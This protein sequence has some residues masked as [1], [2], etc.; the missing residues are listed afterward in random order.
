MTAHLVI[1]H[2]GSVLFASKSMIEV[3]VLDYDT[4]IDIEAAG[5]GIFSLSKDD[6]V[7]EEHRNHK[8]IYEITT[9]ELTNG[10]T[11]E[12]KYPDRIGS[13]DEV[14]LCDE[15]AYEIV[16]SYYL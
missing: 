16:C 10:D 3:E 4:Q 11:Y 15:D 8:H 1:S 7:R 12:I 6:I 2:G 5:M 14:E 9:Y 13:M